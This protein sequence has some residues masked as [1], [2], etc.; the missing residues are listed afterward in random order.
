ME[1]NEWGGESIVGGEGTEDS[2]EAVWFLKEE[3][4]A[5]IVLFYYFFG[6][7]YKD[8]ILPLS[9]TIVIVCSDQARAYHWSPFYT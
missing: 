8:I 3:D 7:C 1:S 6:P 9:P 2:G 4:E 5:L